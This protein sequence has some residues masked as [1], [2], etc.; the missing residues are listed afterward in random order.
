MKRTATTR[1]RSQAERGGVVVVYIGVVQDWISA[2]LF[3]ES[4]I[5]CADRSCRGMD[6]NTFHLQCA[7]DPMAG[8]T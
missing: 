3:R 1:V 4:M 6:S 7:F 8:S 2:Y 5:D